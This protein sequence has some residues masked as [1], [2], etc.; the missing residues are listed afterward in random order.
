[1]NEA[2]WLACNDPIQMLSGLA[3]TGTSLWH[4]VA[5]ITPGGIPKIPKL[6][7]PSARKLR[8]FAC[9]VV[10]MQ[11][12]KNPLRQRQQRPQVIDEVEIW[13]DGSDAPPNDVYRHDLWA[14]NA[15][16][17]AQYAAGSE[18]GKAVSLRHVTQG[19]KADL[20]REML[21]NPFCPATLP[22]KECWD[23]Q[24]YGNHL[25]AGPDRG[26]PDCST[27]VGTGRLLNCGWITPDVLSLAQAA[28]EERVAETQE[29]PRCEGYSI[30]KLL[31]CPDCDN[32]GSVHVTN[33]MLDTFRLNLV[34]DILIDAGCPTELTTIKKV[35]AGYK[36]PSCN[37]DGFWRRGQAFDHMKKCNSSKCGMVWIP[38]SDEVLAA[39]VEPNSLLVHLRSPCPHVRGCWALD[40]V[41]GKE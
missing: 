3:T 17:V 6:W 40:L 20:L 12:I 27:C 26:N 19:Q 41:L 8:L 30:G 14:T 34:A 5:K 24:G 9:N 1:M 31:R 37:S 18:W 13:A 29:C 23:C 35:K 38:E 7:P 16:T 32:K 4:E 39:I 11:G 22:N 28:Y 36:C 33:G 21:G 25:G 2:Q 10:R 15:M